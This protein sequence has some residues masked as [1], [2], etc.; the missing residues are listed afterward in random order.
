[1]NTVQTN[2]AA[3]TNNQ[4]KLEYIRN[5][6]VMEKTVKAGYKCAFRMDNIKN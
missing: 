1:M 3:A 2:V 4:Q 6:W 5:L